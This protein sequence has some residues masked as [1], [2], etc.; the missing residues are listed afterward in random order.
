MAQ[1]RICGCLLQIN[2]Q[3]A[4]NQQARNQPEQ[5]FADDGDVKERE[6]RAIG[7]LARDSRSETALDNSLRAQAQWS[8]RIFSAN[9]FLAQDFTRTS[10]NLMVSW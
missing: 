10:R 1:R 8:C 9:N 5:D 3:Y 4:I 6:R 7:E 2:F